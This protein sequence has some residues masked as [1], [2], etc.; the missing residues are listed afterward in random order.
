MWFISSARSENQ[1]DK[2]RDDNENTYWQS[3][4]PG[5]HYIS[6]EYTRKKRVKEVWFNINYKID[7]SYCPNRICIQ[8]ED[9]FGDWVDYKNYKIDK[10][11]G[12]FR[13]DFEER[14]SKGEIIRPYLKTT[15]IQFNILTNEHGGKDCH[16]RAMKIFGPRDHV[17]YDL[18]NPKFET[19]DMLQYEGLR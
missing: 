16:I 4:G 17:S 1:L 18:N 6:M 12:W 19:V 5:P 7:E 13:L 10:G 11:N 3:D 2:L 9:C 14:N 8:I 15:G